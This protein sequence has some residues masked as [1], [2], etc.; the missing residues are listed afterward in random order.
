MRMT[1]A[2]VGGSPILVLGGMA[3]GWESQAGHLCQDHPDVIRGVRRI[4]LEHAP[5]LVAHR[6][7]SG[8]RFAAPPQREYHQKLWDCDYIV[9]MP[10]P[11]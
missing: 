3:S 5:P 10:K 7:G 1:V 4:L 8:A 2:I 6:R 9:Q 11:V